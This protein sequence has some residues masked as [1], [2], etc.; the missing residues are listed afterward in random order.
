MS[1]SHSFRRVV[2][3]LAVA[4]LGLVGPPASADESCEPFS[5]EGTTVFVSGDGRDFELAAEGTASVGGAF[6]G[7]I[8]GRHNKPIT[9][10]FAVLTMDFGNGDTLTLESKIK[11]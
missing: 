8:V 10:Q 7:S 11:F 5:L 3:V 1:L 6:T 9:V 4:L 2:A